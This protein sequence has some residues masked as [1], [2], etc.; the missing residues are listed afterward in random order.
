MQIQTKDASRLSKL[1]AQMAQ[2]SAKASEARAALEKAE[3]RCDR[4]DEA[5]AAL[6]EEYDHE[7][8]RLWGDSPD[9]GE[10]LSSDGSMALFQAAQALAEAHGLGFGSRWSDTKQSVLH[11]QLNRGENGA[12]ERTAAAL[13]YFAPYVKAAPGKSRIRFGVR[14]R[15]SS[16]FA[17][18]L[19]YS[20]KTGAAKVV[21]LHLGFEDGSQSFG[22]LEEALRH[23]EAHH[24]V[25]DVIDMPEGMQLLAE[26]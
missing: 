12:V 15:E 13:R 14:H 22:T 25:E 16:D 17:I 10:L 3:Q 4:A 5:V 19:Q 1:A 18:E 23:I 7:R 9:I 11:V 26:E 24:W 21:R 8:L 2:A 6:R 20:R